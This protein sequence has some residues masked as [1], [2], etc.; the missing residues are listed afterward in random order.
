MME[1]GTGI[2]NK[3]DS[4]FHRWASLSWALAW[5]CLRILWALF[6]GCPGESRRW[7]L[8]WS[9]SEG[10]ELKLTLGPHRAEQASPSCRWVLSLSLSNNHRSSVECSW[11]LHTDFK[12]SPVY[13]VSILDWQLPAS[14]VALGNYLRDN[15]GKVT[16]PHM[17]KGLITGSNFI[18]TFLFALCKMSSLVFLVLA[19]YLSSN[20]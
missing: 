6:E 12:W 15:H 4:S 11:T 7:A 3:P 1:D 10:T 17:S 14:L 20:I 9:K 8:Y 18:V 2:G 19:A 5:S 13:T 16:S